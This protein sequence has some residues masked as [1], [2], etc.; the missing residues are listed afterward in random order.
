MTRE[1]KL[2]DT[3]AD[4][5]PHVTKGKMFGAPAIKAVNGKSAAIFWKNE[6]ICKLSVID[7]KNALN[8]QGAK[9]GTHLY[10]PDR[11]MKSWVSVPFA[12]SDI[13]Q[14]LIKKALSYVNML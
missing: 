8:L 12:H 10:A 1:E 6:M 11:K 5:L 7:E 4:E 2:F 9:Q 3:I 14:D 13:W